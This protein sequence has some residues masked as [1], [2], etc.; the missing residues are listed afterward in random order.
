M[1]PSVIVVSAPGHALPP[2]FKTI[3]AIA[4]VIVVDNEDDLRAAARSA[5]IA[6]Q[7]DFGSDLLRRVGPGELAWIHTNSVGIDAILSPALVEAPTVVTNTRGVFEPP[8]AEYVLAMLLYFAVDL[9]GTVEAQQAARWDKRPTES[10]RSRRAL[11]LGAGGVGREI[12]L[13]LRAVGISVEVVGRTERADEVLGHIWSSAS[14]DTLLP[15]TDDLIIALPLTATTRRVIDRRRLQLLP[16]GSRVVNVGRGPLLDEQ[17][18]LEALR[19][20]HV[21]AA[22]LDVFQEEPLPA[23]HP[24]WSMRNVLVSPHMS[25]DARGWESRSVSLFVDNL[26]RWVAGEPLV[27]VVDK[28]AL[29]GTE[30]RS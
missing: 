25:S 23:D 22:A 13:M 29:A 12:V 4:D 28:S 26:N 30:R 24:F 16:P 1:S 7:W 2:A 15:R 20:G 27:N 9:R 6:F 18:L 21:D 19:S 11:V 3:E 14:L 17:A 10:V 5:R 8:M